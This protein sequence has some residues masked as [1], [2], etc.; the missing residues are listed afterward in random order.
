MRFVRMTACSSVKGLRILTKFPR[1]S[2]SLIPR[3]SAE[4][5]FMKL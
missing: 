2:P 4:A 5:G 3:C 1:V